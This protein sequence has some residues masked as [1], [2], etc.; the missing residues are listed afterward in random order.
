MIKKN[1]TTEEIELAKREVVALVQQ[2]V[3]PEDFKSVRGEGK[4]KGNSPLACLSP[5]VKDD[6]VLRV[7]GRISRAPVSLDT[8]SPM[9]LP[10]D[11]HVTHTNPVYSRKERTLLTRIGVN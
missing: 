1:V 2:K 11:H 6:Q 8:M 7:G 5:I 4:V 3:Y 9:I 10:H